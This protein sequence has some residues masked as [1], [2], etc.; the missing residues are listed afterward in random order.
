MYI[1]SNAIAVNGGTTREHVSGRGIRRRRLDRRQRVRLAAD[2]VNRER[3][4]D[5]SIGQVAALLNVARAEVSAELKA[6]V[7]AHGSKGRM[8]ALVKA[9][10]AA[11]EPEREEALRSIGCAEVWDVLARVVA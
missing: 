6:R 1:A 3:Q 7:A 5:P 11:T 10:E 8:L 4:L 2:L 9:W